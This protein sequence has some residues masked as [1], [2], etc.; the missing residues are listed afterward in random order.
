MTPTPDSTLGAFLTEA[1]AALANA[2]CDEPRRRAR[3]LIAAALDVEPGELLMHAGQPLAGGEAER[4]RGLVARLAKGEP[5][6][7]IFGRRE[8]WGLDFALSPDT[9]DP[10]PDSETVIEAVLARRQDRRAALQVLDLGTGTGCL[11]CAIL[12]EYP[13]ASGVG[14]DVS[15]GAAATARGNAR[16]LGLGER[17]RFVVGNWADALDGRFDVIVANPPYISAGELAALPPAVGRYDPRRALDGGE[18]GLAAYRQIA[19]RICALLRPGGLLVAEIGKGQAAAVGRIFG[20]GGL[21]IGA[22]ERDLAGIGRCVVATAAGKDGAGLS[23]NGQK[24]LCQKNLGMC[25][26]RV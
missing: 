1:A 14:V 3:R 4:L 12:T 15:A 19:A 2:G 23:T 7:R 18:D 5:S 24:N 6:S 20:E 21:L 8:F 13:A 26:R 16:A 9:L 17:A 22:V 25:R 10:R 11:L